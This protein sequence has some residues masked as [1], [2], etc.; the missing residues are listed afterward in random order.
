VFVDPDQVASYPTLPPAG[1]PGYGGGAI[2]PGDLR[3]PPGH[4]PAWARGGTYMTVRASVN[5]L[6]GWDRRSLE[7]QEQTIG[8]FKYSGAILDLA[9]DESRVFDAPAF[10]SDPN[11]LTVP[12]ASHVRKTNPR[13]AEDLDRRIFR[14]G[15]P[16]VQPGAGALDRGL[17]FISFART[18]STQF[19]FIVRAWMRNP[20]FPTPGAGVDRLL[21]FDTRVLGGGYYFVPAL[22]RAN[23]PASWIIPEVQ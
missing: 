18:L 9:D 13:R 21:A 8:R 22:R 2:F 5:S 11:N 17:L 10:E 4:E 19:E 3:Q 15:Y 14:R 20:D 6:D 1:Q 23:D 12:V 16:L 7:A